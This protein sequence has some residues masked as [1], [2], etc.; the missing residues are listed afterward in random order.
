M[1]DLNSRSKHLMMTRGQ[2]Y[3]AIVIHTCDLG[4]LGHRHNGGPLEAGGEYRQAKVEVE[5]VTEDPY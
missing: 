4:G 3:R 5:D 2:C 1:N